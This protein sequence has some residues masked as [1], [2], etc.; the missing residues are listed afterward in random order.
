LDKLNEKVFNLQL[1]TQ[2]EIRL[3]NSVAPMQG[4]FMK[5]H[6]QAREKFMQGTLKAAKLFEGLNKR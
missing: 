4:V 5:E 3:I 2:L 6:I 1:S